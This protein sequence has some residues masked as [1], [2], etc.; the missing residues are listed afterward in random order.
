VEQLKHGNLVRF[1]R[2]FLA[3]R[4]AFDGDWLRI[5]PPALMM[6]AERIATKI[7]WNCSALS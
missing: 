1:K 5:A 4:M 7:C 2:P 6:E 3:P